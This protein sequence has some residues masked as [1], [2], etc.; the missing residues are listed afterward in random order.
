M[1]TAG[2]A[3]VASAGRLVDRF[4]DRVIVPIIHNGGILG[5]VGRRH[6]DL[7]DADRGGPENLN[8]ADT[9]CSKGRPTLGAN[10]VDLAD[11]GMPV[12][13]EGPMDA[14][15]APGQRR[16]PSV[17]HH[18][19]PPWPMS[20]PAS[21]PAIGRNPIVA[22]DADVAGRVAAERDFSMLTAY[23]LEPRIALLL[24]GSNPAD[25]FALKGPDGAHCRAGEA[26]PLG[27]ELSTERLASLPPD[28]ARHEAARVVAARPR[29]VGPGSTPSAPT[30]P[31]PYLRCGRPCS[32]MSRSGTAT[33]GGPPPIPCRAS[34]RSRNGWP[35][36]PRSGRSSDGRPW[37]ASST[38]DSSDEATGQRLAR[39]LA[40]EFDD[41]GHD[42]AALTEP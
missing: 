27:D 24:D 10:E 42:V 29:M 28:Q 25:L 35:K 3:S 7:S 33:R 15:A 23:R 13:V 36:R 14:I 40:G 8:T 37:P 34:T 1:T 11:G 21:S 2:V 20:G 16:T 4:R 19:V 22:T 17:S 9:P 30:S 12:I 38:S 41:Q 5:F 39:L 32:P 26:R 31:F 18:S 6:P